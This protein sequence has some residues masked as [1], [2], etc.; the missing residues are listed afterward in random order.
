MEEYNVL[1]RSAE[2]ILS[3]T[4]QSVMSDIE[5]AVIRC[6]ELEGIL[7]SKFRAEGSGLVQQA[8]NIENSLPPEL[9]KKLKWIGSIR[10]KATHEPLNFHLPEQYTRV[11]D[12]A[13]V[14]LEQ[15]NKSAYST[16]ENR[17]ESSD[18]TTTVIRCAE[19]EAILKSKFRAEGTGL[20]QYAINVSSA[21]PPELFNN[22]K[23]IGGVR[24]KATHDPLNFRMPEQYIRVCDE[25]KRMLDQIE[26]PAF[27]TF[28]HNQRNNSARTSIFD[29]IMVDVFTVLGESLGKDRQK[30]TLSDTSAVNFVAGG[31]GMIAKVLT[32]YLVW[33]ALFITYIIGLFYLVFGAAFGANFTSLIFWM[34]TCYG[35]A[36]L[37]TMKL[38]GIDRSAAQREK[39]RMPE[40]VLHCAELLGG[41]PLLFIAQKGLG[42]KVNKGNY[43]F[44][45]NVIL[46]F[47]ASFII[48]I[49]V[50]R[51]LLWWVC[52]PILFLTWVAI[53]ADM[54]KQK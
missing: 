15:L 29:Q 27:G 45:F 5:T 32:Q 35:I 24:N 42:H 46:I 12:E 34:A 4:Q 20:V 16:T 3:K 26:H 31:C 1:T 28:N 47:H 21:L 51:G 39:L 11:C 36:S 2:L 44:V 14:M 52:L 18:I 38:Y 30:N 23:W 33:V 48:N 50:F 43:Q 17:Q 49:F 37:L 41:W 8:I 19:L 22:L 25:T 53:F 6:S 9:F 13:K 10:N 7:K 54:V 40:I